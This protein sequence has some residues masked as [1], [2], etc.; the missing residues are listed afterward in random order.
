MY[1]NNEEVADYQLS[2]EEIKRYISSKEIIV[3]SIFCIHSSCD[4]AYTEYYDID[5]ETI[6]VGKSTDHYGRMLG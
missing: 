4:E 3:T 2:F 5:S 6:T 1:I